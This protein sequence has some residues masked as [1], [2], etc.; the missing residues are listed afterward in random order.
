[1]FLSYPV[2]LVHVLVC[3]PLASEERVL[4]A[5][6]LPVEEGRQRR[7]LLRQALDLEVSAQEGVL[8]VHVLQDDLHVVLVALGPLV[9]GEPGPVVEQPRG[10][11]RLLGGDR[12]R[13]G[14]QRVQGAHGH[15]GQAE[16]GAGTR[17]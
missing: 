4:L 17:R 11:P 6:D 7:V 9:A 15:D 3:V 12:G 2:L 13:R 1:M 8:Q 14:G 5:D 10:D 16:S